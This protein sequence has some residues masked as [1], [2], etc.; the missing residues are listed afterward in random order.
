MKVKKMYL[1]FFLLISVFLLCACNTE[2]EIPKASMPSERV[3]VP[4]ELKIMFYTTELEKEI[5]LM[6]GEEIEIHARTYDQKKALDN[7]AVTWSSSDEDSIVITPLDNCS[8]KLSVLKESEEVVTLTSSCMGVQKELLVHTVTADSFD[9]YFGELNDSQKEVMEQ[10]GT[11]EIMAST[12][13]GVTITPQAIIADDYFLYGRFRIEGPADASWQFPA[14]EQ[15]GLDLPDTSLS[16]LHT[17]GPSFEDR[18]FV[19]DESGK[20]LSISTS[21]T[22]W[23][24]ETPGDN[25]LE[26]VLKLTGSENNPPYFADGKPKTLTIKNIW[27]EGLD[28]NYTVFLE[29]PW[30]FE[31]GL[32]SEVDVHSLDVDGLPVLRLYNGN[33]YE[34][35]DSSMTLRSMSI[36]PISLC[37]AYDYTCADPNIAYPGPGTVEIVMIDGRRIDTDYQGGRWTESSCFDLCSLA[38]PI[39]LEQ[40]AYIQF[41]NQQ[42]KI[43]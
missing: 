3:A 6:V 10:I 2:N 41:G 12:S 20:A 18:E 33:V 43:L 34:D 11:R 7:V 39:D 16:F 24:D 40:V 9:D 14:Y 31:V 32:Y 27:K 23:Y 17:F 42:I 37:Y 21:S 15:E 8:A 25:V 5:T 36:S 19:Y 38:S 29:G 4:T 35:T 1:L 26:F 13:N 22:V 28:K 30:S